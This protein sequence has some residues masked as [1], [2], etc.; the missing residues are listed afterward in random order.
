MAFCLSHRAGYWHT[1][2]IKDSSILDDSN[3]KIKNNLSENFLQEKHAVWSENCFFNFHYILSFTW[4]KSWFCSCGWYLLL[5][6]VL[7]W[8]HLIVCGIWC[9][10]SWI[11]VGF[12]LMPD[13]SSQLG[14][15]FD[16]I[17][18]SLVSDANTV[19]SELVLCLCLISPR[20]WGIVLI[21]SYCLWY[22]MPI[23]MFIY[24]YSIS[25]FF[26]FF[27][28]TTCTILS[29]MKEHVLHG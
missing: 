8:Y 2:S 5:A 18:L 11:W 23:S 19:E 7:F 20:G 17:L 4:V 9:Q 6:G 22:L 28:G 3:S 27:I 25:S 15:C 26:T 29:V 12:V 21:S 13:I 16:I 24:H 14:Y 10:Y 1:R